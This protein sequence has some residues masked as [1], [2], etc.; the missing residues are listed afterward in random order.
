MRSGW[1]WLAFATAATVVVAA[2]AGYVL[3]MTAIPRTTGGIVLVPAA[4]LALTALGSF[5]I[6]RS[7]ERSATHGRRPAAE[8]P[9]DTFTR[10]LDRSR[11]FS[12][13][14]VL[15][16]AP[17][18]ASGTAGVHPE[19]HDQTRKLLALVLRSIDHVW[20]VDQSVFVLLAE[21]TL[22]SA[23]N[24]VARLRGAVPES[25]A[26]GMLEVA[27]F[28]RDGLTT[29]GLLANLHPISSHPSKL[30][31]LPVAPEARHENERTG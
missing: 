25:F 30:V 7:L 23:G 28:P 12:R 31:R 3:G 9:W 18:P 4:V 13:S 20:F 14:F 15:L 21:T 6:V 24:A 16:R 17:R 2:A 1:S 8:N 22:E 11:R 29:G 10:E 19:D 27:E 26:T 5:Q